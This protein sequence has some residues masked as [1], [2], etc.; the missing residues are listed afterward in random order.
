M[1]D[2]MLRPNS[3]GVKPCEPTPA[4]LF[5]VNLNH[6]VAARVEAPG[7]AA[8][9]GGAAAILLPGKAACLGVVVEYV[10][11]PFGCERRGLGLLG[12][13]GAFDGVGHVYP[14]SL[15]CGVED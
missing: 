11:K 12:A 4:V 10:A 15:V 6:D 5:A 3:P 14:V 2:L 9:D 8:G 7:F 1:V 13:R